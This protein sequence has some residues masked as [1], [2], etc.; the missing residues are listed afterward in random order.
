MEDNG[1]I[2]IHTDSEFW[3]EHD[4][5]VWCKPMEDEGLVEQKKIILTVTQW[6]ATNK[7][8]IATGQPLLTLDDVRVKKRWSGQDLTQSELDLIKA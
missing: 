2:V 3:K 6:L 1:L 8:R 4:N 5:S 7:Y